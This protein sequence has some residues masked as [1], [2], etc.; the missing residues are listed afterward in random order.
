MIIEIHDEVAHV[1][2]KRREI[3]PGVWIRNLAAKLRGILL[4]GDQQS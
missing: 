3:E 1:A 4:R 2:I